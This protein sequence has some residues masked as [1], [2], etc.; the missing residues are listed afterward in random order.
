MSVSQSPKQKHCAQQASDP[1]E[2]SLERETRLEIWEVTSQSAWQNHWN[3]E[4]HLPDFGR[5]RVNFERMLSQGRADL[6]ASLGE[7][8]IERGMRQVAES[9]DEG[10]TAI[11]LGDILKLVF[12]GV[13]Q[14]SLSAP[15]R[16]LFAINADLLDDYDVIDGT[17]NPILNG[18]QEASDWSLVADR[19]STRLDS[20]LTRV[21]D[22]NECFSDSEQ[23]DKLTTW[24]ATALENSGRSDEV[25]PLYE[26]EARVTG[27]YGRLV[28]YL[29]AKGDLERAGDWAREGIAATKFTAPLV[30]RALGTQL[31]EL[32]EKTKNWELA[33]AH[34][35]HHFFCDHPS[36]STYNAL[37]DTARH[38]GCE[39]PV[40]AA[41]RRFLET[42]VV[43]YRLDES[44]E[45][46]VVIDRSWPLPVPDD[47]AQLLGDTDTDAS[48]MV[49][50]GH[51]GVL[52]EI[53]IA[54][55]QPDEVLR[56]FD[57]MSDAPAG[58]NHARAASDYADQVATA[59]TTAYPERALEISLDLLN[60]QLA[61]EGPLADDGALVYLRRLRPIHAS[62]DR[63]REWVALLNSIRQTHAN[64]GRLIEL[65]D[66]L[67]G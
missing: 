55:H 37:I 47:V 49:P 17:D 1:P 36:R 41:A 21:M 59:V 5:I 46:G 30:A 67:D 54:D 18:A 28:T 31:G 14:S 56:W 63:S 8:L 66:R 4:G 19:L 65:L 50:Q 22:E 43:P 29:L 6:V 39:A 32:A 60:A 33:A 27:S 40:G 45:S 12:K 52:L 7:I 15:D 20:W 51:P 64:R 10:E 34:A 3:G 57:K 61:H 38:A 23:R 42:G 48:A 25:L 53:A 62:L 24:L 26:A 2:S 44:S 9:D 58:S 35:A 16:L 11:A 13:E